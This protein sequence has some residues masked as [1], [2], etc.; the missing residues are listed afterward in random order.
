VAMRRNRTGER[1]KIGER[2]LRKDEK[3]GK[4]RPEGRLSLMEACMIY[5]GRQTSGQFTQI[6]KPSKLSKARSWLQTSAVDN[7]SG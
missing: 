1:Q 4:A 2:Q 5:D 6:L 7:N 3:S